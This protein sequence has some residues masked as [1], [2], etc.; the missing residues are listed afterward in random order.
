MKKRIQS[1]LNIFVIFFIIIVIT[2]LIPVNYILL[3]PGIAQELSPLIT[4]EN[5]FKGGSKGDFMLTAV[6]SSTATVWDMIY[7]KIAKPS[8][9]II[10]PLEKHIPPGLNFDEYLE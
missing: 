6:S 5:G 4:V 10:E 7:M 2:N 1:F 3:K 8:N 9:V